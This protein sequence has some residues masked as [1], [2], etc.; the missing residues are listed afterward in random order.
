MIV[1]AL[2][3]ASRSGLLVEVVKQALWLVFLSFKDLLIL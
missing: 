1:D 3:L 2:P